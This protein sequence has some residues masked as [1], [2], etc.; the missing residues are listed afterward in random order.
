MLIRPP[1]LILSVQ[2]PLQA[3]TASSISHSLTQLAAVDDKPNKPF[4]GLMGEFKG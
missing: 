4:W 2:S 1:D 3:N